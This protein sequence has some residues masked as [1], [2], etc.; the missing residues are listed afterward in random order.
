VATYVADPSQFGNNVM[1]KFGSLG[2]QLLRQ[3]G[4]FLE[5]SKG[6]KK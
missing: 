2:D 5:A 6:P 4:V 1:P 3:L